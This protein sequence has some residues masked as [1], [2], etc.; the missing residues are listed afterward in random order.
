MTNTLEGSTAY[1]AAAADTAFL[2]NDVSGDV[3]GRILAVQPLWLG[4]WPEW[5]ATAWDSLKAS[6]AADNEDWSVWIRWYE[7]RCSGQ[8]GRES[9]ELARATLADKF[10]DDGPRAVN[11]ELRRLE[12]G[13]GNLPQ[14]S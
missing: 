3:S 6:L 4:P 5:N 10:W 11:G 8:P 12:S 1:R 7:D 2:A 9:L 14:T 13:I